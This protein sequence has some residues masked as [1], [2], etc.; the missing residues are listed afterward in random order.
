[1]AA[2]PAFANFEQDLLKD[3]IPLV[4]S[5]YSV[6]AN[7]E[8]RALAGLSMGGVQRRSLPDIVRNDP[9]VDAVGDGFILANPSDKSFILARRVDG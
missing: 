7:R 5:K 8:S 1:M 3:L 4:E 9:Q 6:K 2:A